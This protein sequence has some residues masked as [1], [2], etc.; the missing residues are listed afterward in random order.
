MFQLLYC[1]YG[2][3][4][5]CDTELSKLWPCRVCLFLRRYAMLYLSLILVRDKVQVIIVLGFLSYG[6]YFK[7][8]IKILQNSFD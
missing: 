3:S 7:N 6:F 2:L 8:K 5:R 4:Y 1:S